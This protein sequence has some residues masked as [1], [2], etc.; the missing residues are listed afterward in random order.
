MPSKPSAAQSTSAAYQQ[1]DSAVMTMTA[2]AK[3]LN[4]LP[5]AL[6]VKVMCCWWRTRPSEED[7]SLVMPPALEVQ[8]DCDL[9]RLAPSACRTGL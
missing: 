4:Q 1:L 7:D 2:L 3:V 8:R 6:K 5:W 9:Q